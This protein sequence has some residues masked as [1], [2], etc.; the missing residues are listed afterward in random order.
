MVQFHLYFVATDLYKVDICLLVNL[1]NVFKCFNFS[2]GVIIVIIL[3]NCLHFIQN[4]RNVMAFSSNG[5]VVSIN[6]LLICKK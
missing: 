2:G 4:I 5:V 1:E 6:N 3:L